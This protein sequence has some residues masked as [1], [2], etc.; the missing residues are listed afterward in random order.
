MLNMIARLRSIA[1]GLGVLT[2]GSIVESSVLS[3][4]AVKK[5]DVAIPPTNILSVLGNDTVE[6]EFYLSDWAN[7]FPASVPNH[8]R[9]FQLQLDWSTLV[10]P[11]SG[12]AL[13][14]GWCAPVDRINC[15]ASAQCPPTFPNCV[16]SP[17][18]YGCTCAGHDPT[19]GVG[20]TES[21]TDF[22]LNGYDTQFAIDTSA[23]G[24][25]YFA[26]AS[27]N[28]GVPDTG[29]PRYL[30]TLV[31]VVSPD[32][33]GTFTINFVNHFTA[34]FIANATPKAYILL[35]SFQPL[36]LTVSEGPDPSCHDGKDNDCDTLS[37]CDDPDCGL[38]P[39]CMGVIPTVSVWGLV[40]LTLLL[41]TGAKVYFGHQ[42]GRADTG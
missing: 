25:R 22:L 16:N 38:E 1:F 9:T 40:I 4:K 3:L 26:F 18:V 14:M 34:T 42:P 15:T 10:S 36:L 28:V 2:A 30:G 21:R 37:D 13:P 20:I 39:A 29:V 24:F 7:D 8:V 11:D 23:L 12:T 31:L 33:C 19:L 27:E 35:P 41:L 5:N 32:A 6:V 17:S